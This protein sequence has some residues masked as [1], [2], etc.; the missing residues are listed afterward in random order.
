MLDKIPNYLVTLQELPSNWNGRY[1]S[2]PAYFTNNINLAYEMAAFYLQDD[3]E[4]WFVFNTSYIVEET[5]M[6]PAYAKLLG[7]L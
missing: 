3:R 1:R 4:V 5:D 6:G 2:R 7:L